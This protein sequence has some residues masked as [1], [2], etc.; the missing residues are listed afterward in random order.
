[1]I[2]D[3]EAKHLLSRPKPIRTKGG[4]N[5]GDP[6]PINGKRGVHMKQGKKEEDLLPEDIVEC[7][8]GRPV[9]RIIFKDDVDPPG[10]TNKRH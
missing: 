3:R 2:C 7:I 8:T 9:E 6:I 10:R 1:M 5:L 4:I